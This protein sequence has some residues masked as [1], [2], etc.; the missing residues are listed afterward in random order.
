MSLFQTNFPEIA[1]QPDRHPWPSLAGIFQTAMIDMFR[2]AGLLTVI[3]TL[4]A[5]NVIQAA[6][7]YDL[8][9]FPFPASQTI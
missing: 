5:N 8:R 2:H 4:L 3:L 1:N 9:V 6:D 7:L